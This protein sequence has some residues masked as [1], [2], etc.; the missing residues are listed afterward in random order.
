MK[1]TKLFCI[2]YAGGSARSYMIWKKYLNDNIMLCPVELAGRGERIDEHCYFEMD[3]L[4]ED[5]VS[6]IISLLDPGINYAIL[7]HSMG[8]LL[9][10]EV[11]YKLTEKREQPCHMFF[12]GHQAPHNSVDKTKYH[13]LPDKEFLKIIYRYGGNTN[14]MMQNEEVRSIF[15]PILR[16]DFKMLEKYDY[17]EKKEK[18]TC[19]CTVINGTLDN[20][21]M[22][23]NIKEWT[24]HF[25]KGYSFVEIEGG[26]FF[27]LDNCYE[28]VDII[29]RTLLQEK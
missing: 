27:I 24:I 2:P 21:I 6:T 7:G 26:H 11:Y 23:Y 25:G 10:F 28:V 9:A 29:N 16:S 18:I 5:I 12:S 3:V 8:A 1:L 4:V 19:N 17:K 20:S 13:L 22:D 15:L 14:L